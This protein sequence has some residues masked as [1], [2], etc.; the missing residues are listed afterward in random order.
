MHFLT[1]FNMVVYDGNAAQITD[2][3]GIGNCEAHF[4][5][6]LLPCEFRRVEVLGIFRNPVGI[7]KEEPGVTDGVI[8]LLSSKTIGFTA[9]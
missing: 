1:G 8:I 6:G 3:I 9:S 4:G 7:L 5:L 2:H